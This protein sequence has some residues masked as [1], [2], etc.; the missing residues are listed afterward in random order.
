MG[1]ST[2]AHEFEQ[3]F[4]ETYRVFHRRDGRHSG[5]TGASWAVLTHLSLSGPVTVGEASLHLDRAQS[6]VSDIVTQLEGKGLVERRTDSADKRRTHVWITP[7]G[8][9][10][11]R[12][13]ESVLGLDLLTEAFERM[14]PADAAALVDSL[15]LLVTAAPTTHERNPHD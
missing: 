8:V 15:R 3:L 7:L 4:R 13:D 9:E 11:L 14:P 6:V 10:A 12:A 1:M 5:L 2:T